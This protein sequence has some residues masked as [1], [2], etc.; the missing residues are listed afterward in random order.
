MRPCLMELESMSNV[1]KRGAAD[2]GKKERKKGREKRLY[3]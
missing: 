2:N 1:C 3:I